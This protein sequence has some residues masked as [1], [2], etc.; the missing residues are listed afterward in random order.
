MTPRFSAQ[1]AREYDD[2]LDYFTH[3]SKPAAADFV[4]ATND[5]LLTIRDNPQIGRNVEG[6]LHVYVIAKFDFKIFYRIENDGIGVASFFHTRREPR[7]H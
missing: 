4:R 2:A 6:A 3:Y 1:A 7:E 5:A